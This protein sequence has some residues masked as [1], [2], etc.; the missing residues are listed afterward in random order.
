M[1]PPNYP[2]R[3]AIALA[4]L[5]GPVLLSRLGIGN[6]GGWGTYARVCPGIFLTFGVAA[7]LVRLGMGFSALGALEDFSGVSFALAALAFIGGAFA[8]SAARKRGRF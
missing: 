4:L 8:E 6:K 5:L 2:L 1:G 7:P 3:T